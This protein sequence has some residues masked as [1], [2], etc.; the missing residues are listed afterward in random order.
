MWFRKTWA[1][2]M[3]LRFC[4]DIRCNARC[5]RNATLFCRMGIRCIGLME[6]TVL[7]IICP[8]H[9]QCGNDRRGGRNTATDVWPDYLKDAPIEKDCDRKV[10]SMYFKFFSLICFDKRVL[11]D[12]L[13]TS[14]CPKFGEE[15]GFLQESENILAFSKVPY[16]YEEL[17]ITKRTIR[18]TC[19]F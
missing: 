14:F 1:R 19:L 16:L 10:R 13:Y 8:G 4:V 15:D 9:N 6:T 3:R 18:K 2:K 12:S 17:S 5:G 7:M 11:Q